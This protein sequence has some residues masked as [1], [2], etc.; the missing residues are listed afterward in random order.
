MEL[1]KIK[2]LF[3][4]YLE[5]LE[6]EDL[7]SLTFNKL[8]LNKSFF[9][10]ESAECLLN[11]Y[12][13]KSSFNFCIF[14]NN[15]DFFKDTER[16]CLGYPICIDGDK[17]YPLFFTE[18]ETNIDDNICSPVLIDN[19]LLLNHHLYSEIMSPEEIVKLQEKLE[20]SSSPFENKIKKAFDYCNKS[21]CQKTDSIFSELAN[22]AESCQGYE[23]NIPNYESEAEEIAGKILSE[24]KIPFETQVE[25]GPYRLD[26]IAYSVFG[27]CFNIEVDGRHH[28][29]TDYVQ[30][31][32]TRDN[33]LM[34]EF[35][36]KSKNLKIMRINAKDTFLR[37]DYVKERLSHLI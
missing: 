19:N 16:L 15:I 3:S 10:T 28:Y 17:T 32:K 9:L 18:V 34:N 8:H 2:N 1:E 24:L 31:D 35:K 22:Y 37:P 11:G 23:R 36:K 33:Y 30:K 13:T 26:F 21:A 14:E 7:K 5:C 27:T 29:T 20:E 6:E 4:F 25:K 12:D